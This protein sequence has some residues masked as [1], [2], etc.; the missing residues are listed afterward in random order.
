MR[1]KYGP[2]QNQPQTMARPTFL[3]IG[4]TLNKKIDFG[5]F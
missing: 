2:I 3:S 1:A 5:H 4:M